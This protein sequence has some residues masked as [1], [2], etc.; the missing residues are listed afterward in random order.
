MNKK[1]LKPRSKHSF[2]YSSQIDL[3]ELQTIHVKNQLKFAENIHTPPFWFLS[4]RNYLL[5][6]STRHFDTSLKPYQNIFFAKYIMCSMDVNIIMLDHF[7]ITVGRFTPSNMIRIWIY[8]TKLAW[9]TFFISIISRMGYNM[10]AS[11]LCTR[12][13]LQTFFYFAALM[14]FCGSMLIIVTKNNIA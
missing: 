13:S 6:W 5:F 9:K 3:I 14:L 10:Y 4:R 1:T 11:I 12:C 2:I 7:E 8:L